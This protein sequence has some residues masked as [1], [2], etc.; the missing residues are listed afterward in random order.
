VSPAIRTDK[1]TVEYLDPRTGKL[2]KRRMRG[3]WDTISDRWDDQREGKLVSISY[4][5]QS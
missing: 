4:G 2:K 1:V 3:D 5:W